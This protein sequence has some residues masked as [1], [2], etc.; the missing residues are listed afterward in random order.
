MVYMSIIIDKG[1]NIPEYSRQGKYPW[2]D[3]EIGD[4]FLAETRHVAFGSLSYYNKK[5]KKQKK[6]QIKIETRTENGKCRVWRIK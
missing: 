2:P 4:S 1:K 6:R 3:L 5:M